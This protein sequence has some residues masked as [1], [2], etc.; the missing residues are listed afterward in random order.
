[1]A[2]FADTARYLGGLFHRSCHSRGGLSGDYFFERRI[3]A[4]QKLSALSCGSA[5]AHE[6][7]AHDTELRPKRFTLDGRRWPSSTRPKS[8]R[9]LTDV[10]L[11]LFGQVSLSPHLD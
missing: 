2:L 5:E 10:L 11:R 7:L 1:M 8:Q 9:S 6:L 4:N 3:N